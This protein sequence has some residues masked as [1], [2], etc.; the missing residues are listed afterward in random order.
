MKTFVVFM[1]VVVL[2]GF[3]SLGCTGTAGEQEV[4]K[5][6]T[7]LMKLRGV[8]KDQNADPTE[9]MKKCKTDKMITDVSPETANCRIGA[10]DV[11]TFWNKCR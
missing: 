2:T 10:S 5:M 8:D 6:C 11:D 3:A 1:F 9:E 4:E 7:Q